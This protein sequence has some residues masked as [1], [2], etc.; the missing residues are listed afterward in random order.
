MHGEFTRAD[1]ASTTQTC[2]QFA[3]VGPHGVSHVAPLLGSIACA[4]LRENA[5]GKF[6][7]RIDLPTHVASDDVVLMLHVLSMR[8]PRCISDAIHGM[9]FAHLSLLLVLC[10]DEIHT[11][12]RALCRTPA[13]VVQMLREGD[14]GDYAWIPGALVEQTFRHIMKDKRRADTF[15]DLSPHFF[16]FLC[17]NPLFYLEEKLASDMTFSHAIVRKRGFPLAPPPASKHPRVARNPFSR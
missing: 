8:D 14:D 3:S 17:L 11:L 12:L 9:I 15:S 5:E 2:I 1:E 4:V 10:R 7:D 16:R 13:H 6:P